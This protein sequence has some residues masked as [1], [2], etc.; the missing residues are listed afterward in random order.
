MAVIKCPE[1]GYNASEYAAACMRCGYPISKAHPANIDYRANLN[2][3]LA[4]I[5]SVAQ[6]VSNAGFTDNQAP[7]WGSATAETN[8]NGIWDKQ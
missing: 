3:I 7:S 6:P 1:C 4:A 2:A 8:P 5:S